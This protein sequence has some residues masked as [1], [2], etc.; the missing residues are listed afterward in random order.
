V[1]EECTIRA[2]VLEDGSVWQVMP[3]GSLVPI[4]VETGSE[5]LDNMTD[6]EIE[7]NALS[8]PDSPPTTDEERLRAMWAP[9]PKEIRERMGLSQREFADRFFLALQTVR[10]WE[11]GTYW[12]GDAGTMLLRVIDKHPEAVLDAILQYRLFKNREE[13]EAFDREHD[14]IEEEATPPPATRRYRAAG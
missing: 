9:H 8:D 4:E 5:R 10:E 7:A 14:E 3:D 11:N 2:R 13:L 1:S 12:H 6:E